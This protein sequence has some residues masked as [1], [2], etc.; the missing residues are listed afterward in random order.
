MGPKTGPFISHIARTGQQLGFCPGP[1]KRNHPLSPMVKFSRAYRPSIGSTTFPIGR[2]MLNIW[3]PRRHRSRTWTKRD[4]RACES[5][6]RTTQFIAN[7]PLQASSIDGTHSMASCSYPWPFNFLARILLVRV[8][9]PFSLAYHPPWLL[10]WARIRLDRDQCCVI[11]LRDPRIAYRDP[12]GA[13]PCHP[14]HTS[15]PPPRT[16]FFPLPLPTHP[17][18]LAPFATTYFSILAFSTPERHSTLYDTPSRNQ[19][20]SLAPH[21]L[22]H[23]PL[24]PP[25]LDTRRSDDLPLHGL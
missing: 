19:Q 25:L 11:T 7:L 22:P 8:E 18:L 24:Q 23:P 20:A 6:D 17:R 21:P 15:P 4:P 5:D 2:I 9:D 16:S 14:S 1:E 13:F 3:R 12:S 10:S